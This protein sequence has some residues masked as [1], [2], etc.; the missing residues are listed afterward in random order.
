MRRYRRGME[1]R[2]EVRDT[3]E[4]WK[5]R[6][7]VRDTDE[8]WKRGSRVRDTDKGHHGR[9]EGGGGGIQTRGM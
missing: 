6:R 3:D 1:E 8:E 4:E 7:E 2:R 5:R 9:E